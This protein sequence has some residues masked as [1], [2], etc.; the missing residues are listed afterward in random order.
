MR[1]G[2]ALNKRYKSTG[3]FL[4]ARFAIGATMTA[5]EVGTS[6]VAAWKR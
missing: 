6:F 1:F 3:T 5:N 4:I 2:A